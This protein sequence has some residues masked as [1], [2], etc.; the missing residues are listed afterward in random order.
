MGHGHPDLSITWKYNDEVI[1]NSSTKYI[2]ES[3]VYVGGRTFTESFLYLCDL[4]SCD[5]GTYTCTLGTGSCSA[6][7]G[8]F[9]VVVGKLIEKGFL[10][11]HC[12]YTWDSD[13]L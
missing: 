4:E 13:E 6:E 8:S 5:S 9:D 11:S 12:T 10:Y 3:T 1:T 2:I 7:D